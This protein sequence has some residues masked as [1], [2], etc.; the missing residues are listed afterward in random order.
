MRRK[1]KQTSR[2]IS[3]IILA[4]M[5]IFS[6]F[7]SQLA[8]A[9]DP[10][11]K[12]FS[13][14][15]L[16]FEKQREQQHKT[17]E[18]EQKETQE[19]EELTSLLKG[20]GI[21]PPPLKGA[22]EN[23]KEREEKEA[24]LQTAFGKKKEIDVI[25]R[26]KEKPDLNQVYP[27]VK[28]KK[29]RADKIQAVQD[30]LKEKASHSQKGVQNALASLETKGK[31]KKKE[32]L[33]I[34]N[35]ISATITKEALEE[36]NQRDDIAEISLDETLSLPEVTVEENPP[37][38]PQWGLEKIYA[39]KV[40]GQYGLKGEGIVVG[41]MDSGVDGNHEALKHNYRGR[42]GNH[43][44]SWIDLSGQNYAT[45][46][47]GNG[48]GTHVA[49]SAVG[50][51]AGE[52]IGVA[53]EAEWIAAKIFNDGGSTTLSA[54]H[55]AFQ[56][57]M[58]PGGDP[59]KAPHVVNNSWGNSNTYNLEF[60]EDVKAWI[61]A[62]I[63]PSFAAG[64][65]GPGSQTIGSPG[66]FPE[67]FAVGATDIHDQT[68][69]FSSRG[70][71]FWKDEN[72]QERRIIKPDISAPGHKIY[73]A[74]PAKRNEG[75]Y[76]TISGTSMATPHVTGGI[77]LLL[78]ANPNLT[79]DQVKET[80]IQTARVEP[81]MG[82]LPNDSYGSGIMNI[83]Q[84][85]TETAFA[86]E[87]KG[88]LKNKEGKPVQGE[89]KIEKEGLS[90]QI[91][92]EGNFSFKIREGSHKV[93]ISSFGYKEFE[94]TINLNRGETLSIDWILEDA[95]TYSLKG[96]V[97]DESGKAVPYAYIR[98]MDTP[99]PFY[100]T[101][102]NGMFEINNL[103]GGKYVLQISG[104]GITGLAKEI[105]A[106][107]N[108]VIEV[109][110]SPQ[111]SQSSGDWQ[112][113]NGNVHRNAVSRNGIDI[114]ALEKGWAYDTSGKGKILFSTPSAT[115]EVLV[116]TTDSGYAV[117]LDAAT[118]EEKWA[119]RIGKT[120]RS[121]P[122]IEGNTVFLSGGEDGKIYAL[123]LKSGSNVWTTAVGGKPIYESPL[124][125]EGTLF[126]ASD[127]TDGAKLTALNAETGEK[128]WDTA[129]S[130][131]TYFGPSAGDGMLFVGSYDNQK[132]RALRIEDGSEVWNKTLVN[133][134][135]ASK[136]VYDNG[137]LYVAGTNFNTEAGTLY[138]LEAKSGKEK[139]K[140]PGI[141]DTQ[142]G[143]PIIYEN[144]VIIGSA[145]QPVLRAFDAKN[146]EEL[147]NNRSVG[148]TL[149]NG[150]VSANGL[151]FF[152]GTSGNLSVIDVY[153]GERLKDFSLP[154]YST[155]GIPIL[156][157]QVIV[158]H[159]AGIQSYSSPGII[160]GSLKD[161]S[162]KAIKGSVTV[163]ETGKTVSADNDGNYVLKHQPGEYTISA[164]FY[165]KKQ[166][167]ETIN[168]V[169][170]YQNTR[171]YQFEEAE[172]GSFA[173][174]ITDKRTQEPVVGAEIKLNGSPIEGKTNTEGTFAVNDV[175]EGT[176]T[177]TIALNGYKNGQTEV[178][179]TAGEKT[180]M[181]FEL[182]PIDIAVLD[183][184]KSEITNLLNANGY[185]AEE[186]GWEIA[187]DPG[188][189]KVIY[190]NGGYGSDGAKPSEEQFK[191][192]LQNAKEQ[193]VS[194]IFT[195]QWGANYGSIHHLK[196]FIQD[197]KELGH[198]YDGGEVRIQVEA[199]HPI[200]KGYKP[201]DRIS[202]LEHNADFAWFNQYSGRTIGKIGNTDLGFVGSGVAYN[203][204]SEESAHLL[205]SSHSTVPWESAKAWYRGQQQILF[206]SIDYL[207]SATFGKIT[208][209]VTNPSGEPVEGTIEVIETGV[210][211][212]TDKNGSFTFFHDEGDFT[213]EI[214]AKGLGSKTA[215]VTVAKGAVENVEI[216]LGESE[217]GVLTGIVTDSLSGM[218]LQDVT[219]SVKNEAG[220]PFT[221]VQTGA[222][223]RYEL[224]GLEEESYTLVFSKEGYI[225]HSQ[226]VDV[227]RHSGELDIQLHTM[228]S[229][230]VVGDYF[231]ADKNFKAMF[232]EI[233]VNVLDIQ[234]ADLVRRMAEFDVIFFNEPTSALNKKV[235][236]E[237]MAAADQSETSLIFG[238][239]YWSGSGINHLV[240]HRQDPKMRNTIRKTNEA[241][242]Y[243]ILEE[244][245]IFSGA[246]AGEIVEILTPSSSAVGYFKD[247]SGYPLAE[248]KHEGL[249]TTHGLGVAY[250]PR[251]GRSVELLMSGHGFT[252][253]HGAKDYTD[254]GKQMLIN[255]VLWAANVEFPVV[256]GT[257][258]DEAGQPLKAEIKVKGEPFQT[259]SSVENG[260]FSIA[261][262]EG[263]YE[264]E[265]NAF[266][267][268]PKM[269][270]V[271]ANQ[272][273]NPLSISME[274]AENT[275]SISGT[276]ENLKDGNAIEGA[277]VI[278]IGNPREAASNLQGQYN[279]TKIEPG[280][281]TLRVEKA[282]YVRQDIPVKITDKQKAA[283]NVKLRPSPTVGVIV[284]LTASGTTY[285]QYLEERG[286]KVISMDYKELDK[287]DEVD[288]V[289][290]NSDYAPSLVPSKD[291]FLAFQK[292][293]DE[294]R[295]SVIWTGQAGGRG[296]IRYLQDYMDDPKTIFEH[297]NKP[298]A[299]GTVL[300]EHPLTSG[301]ETGDTIEIP[302]KSGY[303]Y[304]FSGYS[305]TTVVDFSHSQTG[306]KG[307]MVA[308]KG[309]TTDSVE[310]L[311]ANMTISHVFKPNESFDPSREQLLANALN[312]AIDEK[313]ALVGELHGTVRNENGPLKATVTVNE[314]GKTYE[315]DDDGKFFAALEEGTYTLTVEAFG[316]SGTEFSIVIDNGELIS[317][318]F[319]IQSV[320][321]G[322]LTGRIV[323]ASTKDPIAEAR[324]EVLGTP[325]SVKTNAEGNY[326]ATLPSGSYEV[327]VIATGYAPT[328]QSVEITKDQ[329]AELNVNLV[330]SEKIALLANPYQSDKI[331]PFLESNGYEADLYPYTEFESL[332]DEIPNYKLV[333]VND[334]TTSM[335]KDRLRAMIDKANA[336]GVSMIFTAMF[337][338]PIGD[339]R[340]AYGDPQALVNSYAD[341]EI[342][343]RVDESHPILK[344]FNE[345]DEI[346]FLLNPKGAVQ[347]S[348]YQNY[349]GTSLATLTN[350]V[351]GELGST[352]GY[353][354]SSSNSVHILLSAL[355]IGNYGH[356]N[357]RWTDHAKA[358]Y[359]NAIDF[360]LTASQ[361]EIKGT[362][363]DT[364]GKPV[365]GA[366]VSIEGTNM[367]TTTNA[368]GMYR[369]GIGVG[370]YAVKVQARGFAEQTKQ[371]EVADLGNSAD[372]NFTLEAINGAD[373]SGSIMSKKEKSAIA[374]A[375]LT[376]IP[377][378]QPDFYLEARS[379][380]KGSFRFENLLPGEYTLKVS[381]EGYLQEAIE[382]E[383]GEDDK[384]T[385]IDLNAFEAAVLGDVNGSLTA[386][387]NGQKLYAE[388]KGWDILGNVG[389]Y[390]VILVNTNKGTKEQF[391]QLI[392]ESDE[393]K[394]TLV[395]TGSWGVAEGSIPRLSEIEGKPEMDQQGYNEGAV[396]LNSANKHPIFEGLNTDPDGRIKIHAARSPYST[397]KNYPGIAVASLSVDDKSK[398][399]SI[400]Y[401][402]R[403]KEH[404]H[405]LMSSF[406][407]T[408]IIG[409][410][411]GWTQEGRQ[412]FINALRWS[413]DATQE[414]P[415]APAFD[416]EELIVKGEPATITGMADSGTTIHIYEQQGNKVT[417]IDSVKTGNDGKFSITLDLANGT[418]TLISEAEN[419]AGKMTSLKTMKLIITG[420]PEKKD[421]AS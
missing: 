287:L 317:K 33:W 91:G 371:A 81:H 369:F 128:K 380:E 359:L 147:W 412:V 336:R 294:K 383:I 308:Y 278:L 146:G 96:K 316:H 93:R 390:E 11:P 129:L 367:K 400:A 25:I 112:M 251:S 166:M 15:E 127:L 228:P 136:P 7:S 103:P 168:L 391:Q 106:G 44:Y 180:E 101:D 17:G 62:G 60:Y 16:I 382:V 29:K 274:V 156:P 132:L 154:V 315:T 73:S 319:T 297:N 311:L 283:V 34:I 58:A 343:L 333:I 345:G 355:K 353:K 250:K 216:V 394:T 277:K 18:P 84:A 236:D 163:A 13:E 361:G 35:G 184:Y 247:Y 133:E 295:I 269:V 318:S 225:A 272:E 373:F 158:P 384:E 123:D 150:S 352:I 296:S 385:N 71:V 310:I 78:Q 314:T 326:Q 214:R 404:M 418:H 49:G 327:R 42:D 298:G 201:G 204:I 206:N 134:G 208:G 421:K 197:P 322:I 265:V 387:L 55:Q 307:S 157:G 302:A 115:K 88:S 205:L 419:F 131:P 332:I 379:D 230:G 329:Q 203:A 381:A 119:V 270:K 334:T 366:L 292:A 179:V 271:T 38:L 268:A 20:L 256:S 9:A 64:N 220:E 255:A 275:G 244:H 338:G 95:L 249:D 233:G 304:G 217:R 407:V 376:L 413:K 4:I 257:I 337:G 114:D 75:K 1:T 66:S 356:P 320:D 149:N 68:A 161:S 50:G 300:G 52:P 388:E 372:V 174:K 328:F 331:L 399:E 231:S 145:G 392:S 159:Q 97:S 263:E 406:A 350:P 264:L 54:I 14:E 36:L 99:L 190:L 80:L 196:D 393:H 21:E 82:S 340:D 138:A 224:S 125:L 248:I 89:L 346:P 396:Y 102:E 335:N 69:Y 19:D 165:G 167:I 330:V 120:N 375:L 198:D 192:L 118:G 142:A 235:F 212:K 143:S 342:N 181:T 401:E 215:R 309:R 305:G 26:M 218:Q 27:Q 414:I 374:G 344:G 226:N 104:E 94:T 56:W 279:L 10:K 238:D 39:P 37:K 83:Y 144:R 185:I 187:D 219:V 117:A 213:I 139:W 178:E 386:L 169:S 420:K 222:N 109:K 164:S 23:G 182:Q 155:S 415:S 221:E 227:A 410:D 289:F 357:D 22:E 124:F 160:K 313:E 261:I 110:V 243:K 30:H 339:L 183:D 234:P 349:S 173:L 171:N 70:P 43:Q 126:V 267:Y 59:S 92:K 46:N 175:F 86:G 365:A 360:A 241:A 90:L 151:L 258:L 290:A 417:L 140:T 177:A 77:A 162:G 2:K 245:P 195:D 354:F 364:Q 282:G 65:D 6:T 199:E 341:K 63:F 193:N 207:Y 121:S 170:G 40:W 153:T 130:A 209:T 98:V 32:S 312:W 293:L 306:E 363:K 411:Y 324:I 85:V 409:P 262:N 172:K 403:S 51:G 301:Y 259:Q 28:T 41:I 362:V 31:A 5:M 53:P 395:F 299:Q 12:S 111:A 108:A 266:G 286:Y 348:V 45:P 79:V 347:Y 24:T 370:E 67:T 74:W 377:K 389:K 191:K 189:Y 107:T 105:D 280:D 246:A 398:G 210:K 242:Q 100:R 122:T 116:L 281:Y 378:D 202:V 72:G 113:A 291:V 3:A 285:K 252:S 211:T 232:R 397:F 194:I 416:Q 273:S 284:D 253:Y 368:E 186:R 135:V 8:Y 61:A 321:S 288:V 254:E 351:K 402:F 303:Y 188:R 148:T 57:F 323:D 48:H 260:G 237:M 240:N 141:G 47:D 239:A 325:V 152:A 176:Y 200:F 223:G 405:L 87:L 137:T 358:I 276:V 408:N 229:V 76:H